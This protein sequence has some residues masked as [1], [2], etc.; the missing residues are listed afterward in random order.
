MNLIRSSWKSREAVK[1]DSETK[2]TENE[3]DK[4]SILSVSFLNE[5]D[6]EYDETIDESLK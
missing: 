3:H 5:S 1:S 2:E 6:F 4:E